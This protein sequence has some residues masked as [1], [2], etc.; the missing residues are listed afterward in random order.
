ML[1]ENKRHV[2]CIVNEHK[3]ALNTDN[4]KNVRKKMEQQR[5]PENTQLNKAMIDVFRTYKIYNNIL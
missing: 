2:V 5:C 4:D 1:L 3:I